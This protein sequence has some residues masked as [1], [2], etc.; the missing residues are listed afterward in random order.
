MTNQ[1]HSNDDAN[2]QVLFTLNPIQE[3][4][5]NQN[6]N[7]FSTSLNTQ[8]NLEMDWND[9]EIFQLCQDLNDGENYMQTNQTNSSQNYSIQTSDQTGFASNSRTND[10]LLN[11]SDVNF[12]SWDI[13]EPDYN[14]LINGYLQSPTI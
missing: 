12:L 1:F 5:S 8:T 9:P 6:N 7:L 13:L 10:S 11:A 14:Q 2:K 4:S 3:P